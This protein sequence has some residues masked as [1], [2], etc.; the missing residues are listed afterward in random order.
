MNFNGLH[1]QININN[2]IYTRNK[3]CY[4]KATN[5]QNKRLCKAG[6]TPKANKHE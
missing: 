1:R 6:Y 3:L 5:E 4:T 2:I